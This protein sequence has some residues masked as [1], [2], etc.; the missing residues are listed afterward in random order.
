MNRNGIILTVVVLALI[1]IGIIAYGSYSSPTLAPVNNYQQDTRADQQPVTTTPEVAT[2][3]GTTSR[4][5]G[6]RSGTINST[7]SVKTTINATTSVKTTVAVKNFTVEGGNFYF[8]PT[9]M[10][11]NKGDKVKITFVNKGGYHDLVIDEFNVRTP[12]IKDG[13]SATIEFTADKTG[14][15]E[16]YCSVGEH[17]QMGM[18]GTLIVK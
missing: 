18:K 2:T 16:Y 14:S 3:T 1:I 4:S 12:Q 11:V 5:T 17:R 13:Q 8:K 15:F 9:S 10:T 7:T 6:P